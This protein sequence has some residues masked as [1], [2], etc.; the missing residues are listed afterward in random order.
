MS[1]PCYRTSTFGVRH[2]CST[3]GD[4]SRGN[5][6]P[7]DARRLRPCDTIDHDRSANSVRTTKARLASEHADPSSTSTGRESLRGD[8]TLLQRGRR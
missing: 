1:L 5:N 6:V 7:R 4:V 2:W 3:A 8:A